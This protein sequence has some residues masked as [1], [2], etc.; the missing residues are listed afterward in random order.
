MQSTITWKGYIATI[1]YDPE[2]RK[3]YGMVQNANSVITFYGSSV[4]ELE[5]EFEASMTEYFNICKEKGKQPDK[6]YSGR[7]HLRLPPHLHGRI[8]ATAMVEGKSLNQWVTEALE[9]T[10]QTH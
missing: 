6:P 10:L 7:F 5:R 9:Q 8:A 1:A 2:I 3:F 4:D